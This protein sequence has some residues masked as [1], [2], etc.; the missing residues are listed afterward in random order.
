MAQ[1]VCS[2]DEQKYKNIF[3]NFRN[4]SAK[5]RPPPS[6]PP[7]TLRLRTK[8]TLPK[9]ECTLHWG[10]ILMCMRDIVVLTSDASP[11][12]NTKYSK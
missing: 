4:P 10:N 8:P 5:I 12:T 3:N 2:R 9:L 1:T 7:P 6:L 11:Q